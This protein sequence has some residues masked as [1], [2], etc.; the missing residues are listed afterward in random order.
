MGCSHRVVVESE[1]RRSAQEPAT[2]SLA[3][4]ATTSAAATAVAAAAAVLA[5][6]VVLGVDEA[7]AEEHENGPELRQRLC[8]RTARK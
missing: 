6:A 3:V 1:A 4:A 7:V 8:L 2:G 5:R